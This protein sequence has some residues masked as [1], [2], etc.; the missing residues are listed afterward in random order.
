MAVAAYDNGLTVVEAARLAGVP[1]KK[2]EKSCEEGIVKKRKYKGH[3]EKHE[4]FHVPAETVAYTAVLK[5]CV[6]LSLNKSLKKK[7]WNHLRHLDPSTESFGIADLGGGLLLDVD[8]LV[9]R[10]WHRTRSYLAKREKHLTSDPEILGGAPVIKGTRI[11]CSSV[12]GRIDGGDKLEDIVDE[13]YGQVSREAFE[14]AY[15]FETCHPPRGRPPAEWKPWR[16]NKPIWTV[17][18]EPVL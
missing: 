16:K 3:L 11:T 4:K 9:G 2:V 10:E 17:T 7:L 12:K 13:H 18:L 14:A 1:T 5:N 6:G 15:E 8:E